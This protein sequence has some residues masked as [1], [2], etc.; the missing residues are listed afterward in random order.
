MAVVLTEFERHVRNLG[1]RWRH[2]L[3]AQLLLVVVLAS[4][5]FFIPGRK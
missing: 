2:Y 1:V 5:F 3:H 4:I